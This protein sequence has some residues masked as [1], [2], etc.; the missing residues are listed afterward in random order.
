M[1]LFQHILD[2]IRNE[3]ESETAKEMRKLIEQKRKADAAR[4]E[5]IFEKH[6]LK[7]PK[8][9]ISKHTLVKKYLANKAAPGKPVR[10][11]V[12]NRIGPGGAGSTGNFTNAAAKSPFAGVA[13][14][15]DERKDPVKKKKVAKTFTQ[16]EHEYILAKEKLQAGI[17]ILE[18]LQSDY[19]IITKDYIDK[20]KGNLEEGIRQ[21]S[22]TQKT[23]QKKNQTT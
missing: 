2:K 10:H 14:Q 7:T 19:G 15:P 12:N 11:P 9:P 17:E 22:L 6:L 3:Y 1:S 20:F 13:H 18:V 23:S 16:A 4:R 21:L 8:K 5:E